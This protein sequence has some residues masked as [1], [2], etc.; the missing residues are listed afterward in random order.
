M[1]RQHSPD[2]RAAIYVRVSTDE[3]AREGVSL[4]FQEERARAWCKARGAEVAKVYRDEGESA[5]DTKRPAYQAMLKDLRAG[6]FNVIAAL[7]IDRLSRSVGDFCQLVQEAE[8]HGVDVVAVTQEIDTT[9]PAGRLLRNMLASFGQF[10]REMIAERVRETMKSAASKGRYC[11]GRIPFG[12]RGKTGG[13]LEPDPA[14]RTIVQE[15][16]RMYLDG[17]SATDLVRHLR[18]IGHPLGLTAVIRLL[19]NPT[20]I[21]RQKWAGEVVAGEHEPLIDRETF[22]AVQPILARNAGPGSGPRRTHKEHYEYLLDG[23][24]YCG[25]CGKHMTTWTSLG[26]MKKRYSYYGCT[27]NRRGGICKVRP[28]N[29]TELDRFV[30]EQLL[31]RMKDPEFIREAFHRQS[32]DARKRLP[33]LAVEKRT[34][35]TA[36]STA[37]QRIDN[38]M[39]LASDGEWGAGDAQELRIELSKKRAARDDAQRR[40]DLLKGE[41]ASVEH[42]CGME[43]D[44]E[45]FRLRCLEQ[46]DSGD[47]AKRR[48][49]FRAV[50]RRVTLFDDVIQ[51]QLAFDSL[52]NEAGKPGMT[53]FARTSFGGPVATGGTL[54]M[55]V[56]YKVTRGVG[57][58]MQPV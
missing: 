27:G 9:T 38:L 8:S 49:L 57:F 44:A 45:E 36:V 6:K 21:G 20:Y 52:K 2:L 46:I 33:A 24:V 31:D 1:K 58:T 29:A 50:L 16:Y 18:T 25:T 39:R 53:E 42:L 47:P 7:K 10:E 35:E 15:L 11:G 32:E 5:K 54:V 48:M 19:Q 40:L 28:Y 55:E 51:I 22:D 17:K 12:Y 30:T 43:G 26:K 13:G 4:D 23:I 56:R 34:A 14:T 37:Q 41:I 3:Q